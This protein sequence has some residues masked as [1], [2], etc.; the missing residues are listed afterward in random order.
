MGRFLVAPP[1]PPAS[2]PLRRLV[3]RVRRR[4]RELV[5]GETDDTFFP[6]HDLNRVNPILSECGWIPLVADPIEA[7]TGVAGAKR[8]ILALLASRPSLRRRF[9]DALSAGPDGPFARWLLAHGADEVYLTGAGLANV[10]AAFLARPEQG[11]QRIYEYRED[12]RGEFPLGPTPQGRG[13]FLAWFARHGTHEDKLPVEDGVWWLF[14]ADERPDRGLLGLFASQ[15]TWQAAVPHGATVFGWEALK[16]YLRREHGAGGRWLRRARWRPTLRP[17]DELT[18]LRRTD[19][20]LD[21][22]F[23]KAAAEAGDAD[24]VLRWVADRRLPRPPRAW[25]DGLRADLRDRLPTTPGVNVLAHFTYPSGLQEAAVGL[26]RDLHACGARVCRRDLPVLCLRDPADTEPYQDPELFDTTIYVTAT[27]TFPSKWYPRT[28]LNPRPGIRHIAC[29]Y[30]E[31]DRLPAE[32]VPE[33]RWADEVWA[34]TRFM[35]DAFR[36]SLS[37]PV[38]PMLPGLEVPAFAPKPRH[39]FRLP[40]D[41]F[42]FLFAFDMGS[43]QERKNPL[44][45]VEAFRRAVRPADR[46]HLAIK[47]S[48]GSSDPKGLA[49]LAAACRASDITLIDRVLPRADTLALLGSADCYVSL[50]RSEG[51]GLGMAET[52]Y[53][54]KPVVATGYSGNMDFMT[55]DTARL[56]DYRMVPIERDDLPYPKGCEWADP[57]V[58]H[59]ASH[60]RW[61]L[62]N[63][64]EAAAL[65]GRAARHI[66]E[67]MSPAAAAKRVGERLK[68]LRGT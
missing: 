62:D 28:G 48:R 68:L 11:G 27:N 43:V 35:A 1:V 66:R 40:E 63:R 24:A 25:R 33:L 58:E 12:L 67:V 55:A 23:P 65:G 37:V 21:A 10:R 2:N 22:S 7:D 53:L 8:F 42:L 17:W 44:A 60:L 4:L 30:W 54:G 18:V 6:I 38:V 61:V 16:D 32:W 13:E 56:V 49:A 39:H 5:R 19:P 52:M 20:K 29:W 9:P 3:R 26:V 31:L 15:P 34:A 46:A 14:A 57:S 47:V 41:R 59:A 36:R 50:H 64:D 45:V 51:L